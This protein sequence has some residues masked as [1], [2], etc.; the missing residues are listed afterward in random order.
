[1]SKTN[2]IINIFFCSSALVQFEANIT[3]NSSLMKNTILASHTYLFA[4]ATAHCRKT[5]C[6]PMVVAGKAEVD[7]GFVKRRGRCQVQRSTDRL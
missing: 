6:H 4:P 7:G 2:L 1:M 5:V 3:S